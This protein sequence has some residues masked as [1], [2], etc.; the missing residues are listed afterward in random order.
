MTNKTMVEL[1]GLVNSCHIQRLYLMGT[2]DS[3]GCS[4]SSIIVNNFLACVRENLTHLSVNDFH[5]GTDWMKRL[6]VLVKQRTKLRNI[7]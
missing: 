6:C 4:I 1:I 7:T 2:V 3:P 5:L